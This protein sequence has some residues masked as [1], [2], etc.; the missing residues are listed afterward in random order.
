CTRSAPLKMFFQSRSKQR[1]NLA[2]ISSTNLKEAP[3]VMPPEAEALDIRRMVDASLNHIDQ[4]V[5]RVQAH[6]DLLREYRQALITAAVTGKLDLAGPA[7]RKLPFE[8][9]VG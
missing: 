9:G 8:A 7:D 4:L 2:S 3:I 6:R 5:R 1:T